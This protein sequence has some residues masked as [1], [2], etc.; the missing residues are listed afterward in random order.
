VSGA[1]SPRGE[2]PGR[3]GVRWET[4]LVS[5]GEVVCDQDDEPTTAG[6][7][8]NVS[9]PYRASRAVR[10]RAAREARRTTSAPSGTPRGP[11]AGSSGLNPS[12]SKE[13]H[14]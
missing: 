8:F 7:D 5:S 10:R 4:E 14:R 13:Q 11:Q 9:I 2:Q 6:P 12:Q 3:P 1:K